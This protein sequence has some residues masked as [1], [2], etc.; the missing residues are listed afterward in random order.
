MSDRYYKRCLIGRR[1][2]VEGVRIILIDTEFI[3]SI[4]NLQLLHPFEGLGLIHE[5]FIINNNNSIVVV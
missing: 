4:R 2:G 5:L 1:T 3:N